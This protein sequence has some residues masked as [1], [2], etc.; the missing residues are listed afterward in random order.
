MVLKTLRTSR[1]K[2]KKAQY[3][4]NAVNVLDNTLDTKTRQKI[5]EACACSIGTSIDKAVAQFAKKAQHL[6]IEE[7][8]HKLSEIQ[9]LGNP[10]LQ[11]DGTI[12]VGTNIGSNGVYKC[13]CPQISGVE[14]TGPKS[15]TYCMCCGGHY[16]YQYENAL[17]IKLHI[18]QI[19]SPFESMGKKSCV[20]I[21]SVCK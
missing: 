1:Q 2:R 18:K 14:I 9:H 21:L 19:S 12:I 16:K 15:F 20:F 17:G 13:P 4:F 10:V 6:S 5:M 3:L 11:A 7:K 8:V